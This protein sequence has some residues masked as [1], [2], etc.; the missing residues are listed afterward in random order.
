MNNGDSEGAQGLRALCQLAGDQATGWRADATGAHAAT[1]AA[2]RRKRLLNVALVGG[3]GLLALAVAA[4]QFGGEPA[5]VRA[6]LPESAAMPPLAAPL[7]LAEPAADDAAAPVRWQGDQ[8]VIDFEQMP[9]PQAVRLLSDATRT[10]VTGADVLPQTA[11][12]S[13]R[14]RT[15]SV[16]FAWQRLLPGHAEF[17]ITC[18][19]DCHVRIT[20]PVPAPAASAAPEAEGTQSGVPAAAEGKTAEELESQPG[21]SC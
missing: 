15:A 8:L 2:L 11:L 5:S 10:A 19:P 12:V 13:L 1:S 4:A 20:S 3:P 16:M 21:G 6:E 18:A 7:P 17:G 14:L 9:L